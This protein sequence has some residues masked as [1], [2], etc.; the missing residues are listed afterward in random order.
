ML[1]DPLQRPLIYL[2]AILGAKTYREATQN[3]PLFYV[4]V[5][6]HLNVNAPETKTSRSSSTCTFT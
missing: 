1:H 6:V 3:P 5:L 2:I 4:D